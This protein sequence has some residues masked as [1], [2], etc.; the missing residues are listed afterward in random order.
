MSEWRG[1]GRR[2]PSAALVLLGLAA[3]YNAS[4][5][6]FGSLRQPDSGFYPTLVCVALIVLGVVSLATR[7]PAAA[8]EPVPEPRGTLRVWLVVAALATYALAL[9]P[10]GFL[11]CTAALVVLLLKGMGGVPWRGSAVSAV[12]AAVACYGLFTRLG[13][14]LPAGMLGF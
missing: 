12:L 9:K 4:S 11:I 13:V 3:L 6:S 7:E 2:L 8:P 5:L 14:P 1:L 10:V